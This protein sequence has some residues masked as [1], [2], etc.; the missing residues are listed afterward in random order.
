MKIEDIFE[1]WNLDTNIDKT[2]LGEEARKIPKLHNKYYKMLVNERMILKQYEA[3]FKQLRLEKYEFFTQGPSEETK[4]KGWK[5]P[6]RGVILKTDVPTYIDADSDIIK[7]NLK[8]SLQQEKVGLLEDIIKTI[9]SR[10][11]ILRLEL[12]WQKFING[13]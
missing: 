11:F 9:N 4:K 2:E 1:H 8:I 10:N 5:L 13:G 6:A 7:M 3:D 12:D